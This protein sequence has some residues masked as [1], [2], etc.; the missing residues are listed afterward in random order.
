MTMDG[1]IYLLYFVICLLF[2]FGAMLLD[3]YKF[4]IVTFL[5]LHPLIVIKCFYLSLMTILRLKS[6]F[7]DLSKL[8]Q[9]ILVSIY[10]MYLCCCC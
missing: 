8:Y 2:T 10:K 3:I 7:S 5:W 6:I 9:F 1:C 4:R